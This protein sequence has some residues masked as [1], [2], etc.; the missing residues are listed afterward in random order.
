MICTMKR[1]ILSNLIQAVADLLMV[2]GLVAAA[3]A[4]LVLTVEVAEWALKSEWPGLTLADGLS[5]FGIVHEAAETEAQRLVDVLMALPL[6]IALFGSGI[7]MFLAGIN[8]ADWGTD[9]DL[10][11]RYLGDD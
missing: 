2:G 5:L 4:P 8:F 10:E 6:A 3:V 1:G 7:F 11:A 9:R